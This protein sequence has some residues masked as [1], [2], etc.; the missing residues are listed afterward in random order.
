MYYSSLVAGKSMSVALEDIDSRPPGR[1]SALSPTHSPSSTR[2][3]QIWYHRA[4][5]QSVPD[6]ATVRNP[7]RL[8][9]ITSIRELARKTSRSILKPAFAERQRSSTNDDDT[10]HASV[11][12]R[13][14]HPGGTLS[15]EHH[16]ATASTR[17][18]GTAKAVNRSFKTAC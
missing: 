4:S 5:N 6:L 8:R 17:L 14:Q 3:S 10:R 9:G 12:V 2:I 11:R 1:D 18:Q 15:Q 7:N 13:A 16:G